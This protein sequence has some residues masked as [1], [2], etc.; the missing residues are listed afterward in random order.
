[1]SEQD[2][3]TPRKRAIRLITRARKSTKVDTRGN[4]GKA[5]AQASASGVALQPVPPVS[6]RVATPSDSGTVGIMH[7]LEAMRDLMGQQVRNQAAAIAAVATATATAATNAAIAG[8]P[9]TPPAEVPL[10]NVD[11]EKAFALLRCSEEEKVTLAVYQLQGNVNTWW[12]AIRETVFL[13]GV[14][15]LW[16]AFLKA[17]NEQYFSK[18]AREQKI[19][20]FQCFRQ[21]SITIDQYEVKFAELSQYAP[22]LIEDPEEKA[23]RFKNGLRLELK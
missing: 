16:D 23:R 13:G 4:R 8:A 22:R 19:K 6:A 14:V 15:P 9:A 11:L 3:R 1:M 7:A 18:R 20:E 5:P 12:R 21:G 2:H 10:G 17:F